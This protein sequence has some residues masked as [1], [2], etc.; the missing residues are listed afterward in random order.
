MSPA[1]PGLS[2]PAML[3]EEHAEVDR[4]R[5]EVE[6]RARGLVGDRRIGEAWFLRQRYDK[7]FT[8]L[9][10][11][12]ARTSKLRGAK[13]ARRAGEAVQA[14]AAA[15]FW[16][17]VEDDYADAIADGGG[18]TPLLEL[19]GPEL[20]VARLEEAL[21]R[22]KVVQGRADPADAPRLVEAAA[23]PKL[24]KGDAR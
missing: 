5:A 3:G 24:L 10:R 16:A 8:R 12:A 18:A 19:E 13:R 11:L 20:V 17:R 22:V 2:A 4:R 9:S 7:E 1:R 23:D 21:V 14:F 15:V 6:Q